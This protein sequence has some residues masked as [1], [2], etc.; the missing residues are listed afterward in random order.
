VPKAVESAHTAFQEYR[1]TNPRVRADHLLK[2]HS[3]IQEAREDLAKILTYESGKPLAESRGEIDYAL[4][5]TRWFAGEAER[6]HGDISTPAAPNR[7]ALTVKQPIGVAVALVPWNFPVSMV[8]RKAAAAL[9]AGSTMIVKPSPETPLTAL[10]LA[11]LAL[12]AGFPVGA[13]NI[14]TP[15]QH[16]TP[17]LSKALCEHPLVKKV[18]FTGSTSVGKLI[19]SW[20]APGLKKLTMELGGNCPFIVFEDSDLDWV[21]EQL[22]ALKWRHA[23]QACI[24]ANRVIVQDTVY[25]EF[26][27][28]VLEKTGKLVIGHGS[29]P[30]VTLGALTTPQG[31]ERAS[32]FAEDARRRGARVVRGAQ[33]PDGLEG[34]FFDPTV[35]VDATLDMDIWK[36]EVFCPILGLY[37]F[38]TEKEAVDMANQSSMGL[39]SYVFTR[40]VHRV[41]R[42]MENLEAGMIGVNTGQSGICS[43]IH[44]SI[45]PSQRVSNLLTKIPQ[46]I[47]LPQRFLLVALRTLVMAKKE[48]KMFLLQSI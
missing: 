39:A 41:W 37:K 7:R 10:A 35:I 26:S 9:A 24:S 15:D 32:R 11:K 44:S 22:M 12:K 4:G 20:C 47:I 17:S 16:H 8:L 30:E 28:I 18:T 23:G 19:S 14:L 13:L 43:F 33:K 6:V 2:W 34:Y 31:V 21:A 48:E 36:Q 3:A 29:N 42:M 40:D 1:L 38:R 45:H 25:Q 27:E 46:D 5:F